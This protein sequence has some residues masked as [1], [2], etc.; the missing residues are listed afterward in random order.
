MLKQLGV[1]IVAGAMPAMAGKAPPQCDTGKATSQGSKTVTIESGTYVYHP[2]LS[3]IT[4]YVKRKVVYIDKQFYVY[5][6]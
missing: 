6:G 3:L 1:L 5:R 2:K 4:T